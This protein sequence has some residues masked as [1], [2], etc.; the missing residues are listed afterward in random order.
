[1]Q[2]MHRMTWS[3]W[4][5]P[6]SCAVLRLNRNL[7][8][9]GGQGVAGSNPVSPT[10]MPWKDLRVRLGHSSSPGRCRPSMISSGHVLRLVRLRAQRHALEQ[11]T[12]HA[13]RA[14]RPA[15]PPRPWPAV[16]GR[17]PH[18]AGVA[19]P[20]GHRLHSPAHRRV[21]RRCFWHSC[22]DH[23]H[24]PKANADYWAAKRAR[25]VERD[26]EMTAL[27]R[28]RGSTVLWFWEHVLAAT[29]AGE[30]VAAAGRRRRA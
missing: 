3:A 17:P 15:H 23:L 24:L 25:N 27:L 18:G 30:I 1:M 4:S 21:H 5:A 12:G 6:R 20:A 11:A 28:A 26:A 13:A 16:P 14:P 29:A 10:D 2:T 22:P 7:W 9:P 19:E 8:T